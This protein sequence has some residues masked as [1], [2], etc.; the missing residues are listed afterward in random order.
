[1]KKSS[2]NASE[3]NH[4]MA[5]RRPEGYSRSAF[6]VNTEIFQFI[7]PYQSVTK[8]FPAHSLILHNAIMMD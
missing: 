6:Q 7:I 8:V 5:P 3:Q 1:M 4:V 2:N